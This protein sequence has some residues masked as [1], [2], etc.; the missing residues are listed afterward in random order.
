MY[1]DHTEERCPRRCEGFAGAKECQLHRD[2][3]PAAISS[4][5]LSWRNGADEFATSSG[6]GKDG[7]G[8]RGEVVQG[9][10]P[11][12]TRLCNTCFT[13][14]FGPLLAQLVVQAPGRGCASTFAGTTGCASDRLA[15]P[16]GNFRQPIGILPADPEK[17]N[18]RDKLQRQPQR[19][20]LTSRASCTGARFSL[21]RCDRSL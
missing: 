10:C 18:A 7:G 17:Y 5:S 15:G 9:R 20:Q 4:P 8:D 14:G 2:V 3:A 13:A 19:L 6:A 11:C 1:F 12:T 21:P 16:A